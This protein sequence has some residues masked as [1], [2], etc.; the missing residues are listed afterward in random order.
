M[1]KTN[2]QLNSKYVHQYIVLR[3]D[4]PVDTEY[5]EDSI[6]VTKIFPV[7]DAAEAEAKRLNGIN[8]NKSC[9]YIVRVGRLVNENHILS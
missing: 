5:P 1:N 9:R 7:V 3:I 8:T 4:I 2:S 6:I